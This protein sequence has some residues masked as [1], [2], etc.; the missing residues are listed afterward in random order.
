MYVVSNMCAIDPSV[1]WMFEIWTNFYD[2]EET[3]YN[4]KLAKITEQNSNS[5]LTIFKC[6]ISTFASK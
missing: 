1:P 5:I 6:I 2:D 3:E 4:S